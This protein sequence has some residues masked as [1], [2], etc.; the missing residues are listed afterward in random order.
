MAQGV[1]RAICLGTL[2]VIGFLLLS[3]ARAQQDTNII[4]SLPTTALSAD[5]AMQKAVDY[6]YESKAAQQKQLRRQNL[7]PAPQVKFARSR[8]DPDHTYILGGDAAIPM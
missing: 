2:A 5:P 6:L 1:N 3:P 8:R 7:K 4:A